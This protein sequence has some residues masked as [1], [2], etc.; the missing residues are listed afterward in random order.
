MAQAK[1]DAQAGLQTR[2][3]KISVEQDFLRWSGKGWI[4]VEA[5]G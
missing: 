1:A 5:V 2:K 4:T 3:Y